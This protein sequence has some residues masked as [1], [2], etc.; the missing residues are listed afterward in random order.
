MPKWR[1]FI[2]Q[3]TRRIWFRAALIGL[4]SVLLA[5]AAGGLAPLI[6]YEFAKL[7]SGS[8]DS[9]LTVLA[10][11]MLAVT[12]FSLTAM[13]TAFSGASQNGTPRATE[14]LVED[15]AA[16][17]ALSTFL[18]AFLF[19]IVGLIALKANL[20]GGEGRAVLLAGTVGVI[21]W[22]SIVLLRWIGQLSNFGRVSD[23]IARVERKARDALEDYEG[24]LTITGEG[25]RRAP[26]HAPFQVHSDEALYVAHVDRHRLSE[27]AK[28]CETQIHL[29]AAAG[30]FADRTRALAWFKD[31]MADKEDCAEIAD[32][33]RAAFAL[34]PSRD[35]DQDPR[36]GV[37]VL[38]EIASRAL[39][40][41]V[42]DP[43]TAIAVLS[44]GLRVF[45]DFLDRDI[46]GDGD[47]PGLSEP[48]L[49]LEEMV[50]D[51]IDPLSR[52]G[53]G[54]VEVGIRIQRVLGSIA[55]RVGDDRGV[56]LAIAREA[57]ERANAALGQS[58]D[59]ERLAQAH[60][61]AFA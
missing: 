42:N 45:D 43:G 27:L 17:N 47:L 40:P 26:G 30:T 9:V 10:S 16:Q 12:T 48:R 34:E 24:P 6:P 53:A 51:L 5:L 37:T 50:R 44:A 35:F 25:C 46:P 54:I 33:V 2:G 20:Y 13:V 61:S 3:I 32:K 58:H 11:S 36:F 4:L 49:S 59:R 57:I 60:K 55:M 15:A 52:D 14:L 7:G 31:G 23:T 22:I 21:V 1:W 28:H 38:G 39:S 56:F 19:S 41:A 8:V 18:G 29:T